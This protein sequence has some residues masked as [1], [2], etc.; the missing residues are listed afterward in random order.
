M[1]ENS[2]AFQRR[3]T[4]LLIL[5][6]LLILL[7]AVFLGSV[8]HTIDSDRRLPRR[9][10][11]LHDRAVRGVIVSADGYTL[12]L[13]HKTYKAVVYA[14]GIDPEKRA[15]F[16]HLFS[17]YSHRSEAE[18]AQ[19][20]LN[21]KGQPK[22]G[23]IT[24]AR[25]LDAGTAIHLR[26]LAYRLRRM[27][28]FRPIQNRHGVKVVYGLDIVES[29]EQREFPLHDVLEPALGY[30]QN[31]DDGHYVE[32][33]GTKGLERYYEKFLASRQDGWV[34]GQR[35]VTGIILR[36]GTSRE[37]KRIDGQNLHL[38]IPLSLQ[39]RV[40]VVLDQTARETGA[41][42]V[43]A[44]VMESRTG[45]LLALA[46]SR[47]FD[48]A[49]I[50][51]KD[52]GNLRPKFAEYPYEAGSVIKPLTLSIALDH[53]KVTPGSWFDVHGG[54]LRL[55]KR[56][57]IRD[58]EAFDALTATDIIVHSSNVGISEIAWRLTGR[59]FHDGLRAFGLG[60][61]SG[62][63]LSGE[64]HG[65][66]KS[67]K[68]LR[69]K[70]DSAN[71][72]YGYGMTVTFAQMLKAYSA[73]N[74]D[75][76]A[77]TPRILDYV[78]DTNGTRYPVKPKYGNHR[79]ISTPTARRIH[80]ILKE[81]VKRGTG[82]RAQYP[83]L[84]IGGKTGTAH[85]S[86]G[87]HGYGKEY[88]SSF[89]GFAND[90]KGHRYTLGVLVIRPAR[91]KMYFAAKSAVPAFRRIVDLLVDQHYLQPNLTAAARQKQIA[92]TRKL[93]ALQAR[94]QRE[95]TRQ[96]KARLKAQ[97]EAIRRQALQRRRRHPPRKH[98]QRH[99]RPSPVGSSLRHKNPV[100]DDTIPDM[101]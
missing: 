73:F 94:K 49:H 33:H 60:R 76:I 84:E 34:R 36:N 51:P 77:V 32:V 27:H 98:I 63:D 95:R 10:A 78:T 23:Y 3:S 65:A 56:F 80:T 46:S 55:S 41:H 22:Q 39:R 61:P 71:Q 43:L 96:I 74:N 11:T 97:R 50:L 79:A 35:D 38:N 69:R 101:F 45:K 37:A 86:Q 92:R 25:E 67:A 12:S 20:F 54:T 87:Q 16:L 53:H 15:L 90:D 52:L 40:E 28:V 100:A 47:R 82:A 66:I 24:L 7:V 68:R 85:I 6:A 42:E 5:Y 89:Y 93:R 14:P 48:P 9:T 21:R 29:G 81:V 44:A 72:A 30:V 2:V 58:D 13:P 4:K 8:W 70:V 88:H 75:G 1:G 99:R 18:I 19:T 17:I 26:A 31:H 59:Q 62:I 83:G 91:P 64:L 57:T